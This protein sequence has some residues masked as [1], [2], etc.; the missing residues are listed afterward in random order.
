MK[1]FV[2]RGQ[3]GAE[4]EGQHP[5]QHLPA[6]APAAAEAEP[7]LATE[8][9]VHPDEF[10]VRL[11]DESLRGLREPTATRNRITGRGVSVVKN[12][13]VGGRPLE[14]TELVERARPNQLQRAP[15]LALRAGPAGSRRRE[16]EFG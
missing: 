15:A 1:Q 13:S 4:D 9:A 12:H 14:E 5:V 7:A 8:E 3:K 11:I 16:S 2:E 6:G 10:V